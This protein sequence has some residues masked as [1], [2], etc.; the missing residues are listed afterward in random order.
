MVDNAGCFDLKGKK[1]EASASL[2]NLKVEV[3]YDPLNMETVT[4]R[5]GKMDSLQ[6]HPIRIGAYADKKP[7]RP[8]GLTNELPDTS[9]FLD[10]LEKKYKE[11]HRI[12]A[13]ALSF[14]DYGKE[15]DR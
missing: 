13:R 2:A 14:A 1:Y 12:Q 8:V 5:Y 11:E 6:A 7:E 4:V 3:S 9:R 15:G 10:A